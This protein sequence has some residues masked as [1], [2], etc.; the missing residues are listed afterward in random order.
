MDVMCDAMVLDGDIGT[1]ADSNEVSSRLPAVAGTLQRAQAGSN[2]S[3][4][5]SSGAG[6]TKRRKRSCKRAAAASRRRRSGSRLRA[7]PNI[8]NV[9]PVNDIASKLVR[10]DALTFFVNNCEMALAGWISILEKTTLPASITSSDPRVLTAF[11]ELDSII[12]GRDS[13]CILQRL[14]YI[15]LLCVFES[16]ERIIGSDHRDGT[17]QLRPGY[18]CSS[19]A[20]EKYLSA[21]RQPTAKATLLERTRFARRLRDISGQPPFFLV[22][23]TNV[24]ETVACVTS[25]HFIESRRS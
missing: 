24:A 11:K 5:G 7:G 8:G 20:V 25:L 13:T 21:Q 3:L 6:N 19:V 9:S 22:I 12:C 10:V 17:V 4:K 1:G 18:G 14:A 2:A 15:Q 23:Y 16:L